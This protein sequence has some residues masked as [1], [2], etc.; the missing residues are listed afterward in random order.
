MLKGSQ[1]VEYRTFHS[2][3]LHIVAGHIGEVL[4]HPLVE[5]TPADM[6]QALKGSDH[7]E[8]ILDNRLYRP[9]STEQLEDLYEKVAPDSPDYTYVTRAQVLD[10]SAAKETLILPSGNHNLIAK[11][12]GVPEL[13][14]EVERAVW[15]VENALRKEEQQAAKEKDVQ[16]S[17]EVTSEVKK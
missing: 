12:L 1:F 2:S 8:F 4:Q 6:S 13:S 17:D 9:V 15:Q 16:K 14:S 11:T 7:L 3:T 10:G 5:R